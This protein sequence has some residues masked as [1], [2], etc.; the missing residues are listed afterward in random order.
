[1]A[2]KRPPNRTEVLP[3]GTEVDY[4]DAIGV[5][6]NPQQRRYKIGDTKLVA[7]STVSGI[8]EKWA[9]TPAAVRL[10][11]EGVIALAADGV[12]I[13]ALDPEQ[14]RSL[15]RERKLYFDSIWELARIRGDI[16]HDHLLHL[17]RDG[18]VAR[19]S[20]FAIDIRAWIAAGMRYVQKAKPKIIGAETIVASAEHGVGGRYDLFAELRDGRRARIDFKTVTE[21]KTRRDS[22]GNDTGQLYPPYDE[23]AIQLD[24]YE[25]TA[26][27]CGMDE[28]DCLMVVRLGP[29]GDYDVTEVPYRP[30]VF[31]AAVEAH[32]LRK[33]I[34]KT[35]QPVQE[36]LA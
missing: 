20:D 28:A 22:K 4:W 17:L 15:M 27:S 12:N 19:L 14:L 36:V 5:D 8:F 3:D 6:G 34:W 13:G 7:I 23:N 32:R 31:L 29:D 16:A 21:W 33:E 2:T 25:L 30:D 35:R 24:G 10:T 18:E 1:M 11:E 26:R 9:L